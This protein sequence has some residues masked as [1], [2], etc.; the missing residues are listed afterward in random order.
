[1]PI[2]ELKSEITGTVWRVTGSAGQA[3]EEDET[4]LIVESMKMEIPVGA[5]E[6]CRIIE[7]SV[8]EGQLI[9]EGDVI[10]RLEVD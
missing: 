8:D 4:L 10:A 9:K 2:L 6:D 3:L 1:M 7:V 5:P